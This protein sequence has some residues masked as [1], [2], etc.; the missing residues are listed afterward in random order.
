MYA[1]RSYYGRDLVAQIDDGDRRGQAEQD[2]LHLPHVVAEP[3]DEGASVVELGQ[4]TAKVQAGKGGL[5]RAG[6]HGITVSPG[7]H[8][9]AVDR[10]PGRAIPLV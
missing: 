5:P 7:P 4:R 6:D 10:D 3:V 9:P 1:I 8:A 2:A